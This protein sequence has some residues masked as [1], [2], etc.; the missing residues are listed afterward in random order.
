ARG[1]ARRRRCRS[2]CTGGSYRLSR[3]PERR[4]RSAASARC[5]ATGPAPT[6]RSTGRTARPAP[7]LPKRA[8]A[9]TSF[10]PPEY[11]Y[12]REPR[13]RR[14]ETGLTYRLNPFAPARRQTNAPGKP[15]FLVFLAAVLRTRA[16]APPRRVRP[17]AGPRGTSG[18]ARRRRAKAG[19]WVAA[20]LS[21]EL[22]GREKS[23]TL[24][25][26]RCPTGASPADFARRRSPAAR[27]CT[28]DNPRHG[29]AA[30][31]IAGRRR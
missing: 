28:A 7:P 30:R 5:P 20:D 14:L 17:R 29:S 10:R 15:L 27:S 25:Q 4:P 11:R 24:A 31:G 12:P 1:T 9:L 8:K 13:R 19:P 26:T 22:E 23:V 6:S 3:L 2:S 21:S 18:A 16:D